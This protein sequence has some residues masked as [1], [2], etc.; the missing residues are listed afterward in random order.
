MTLRQYADKLGIHY[1][2][3]W[4]H[5]KRGLIPQAYQLPT[6]TII[7]PNDEITK[8]EYTVVYC[9]VSSSENRVNLDTQAE[10]VLTYTAAKGYKVG[11]IVKEFGSGV[12]DKRVKLC[13]VLNDPKVTRIVVEHKDRLTRFGFNYLELLCSRLGIEI[14][15]INPVNGDEE[16]IV[17]DFVSI[18]TSFCARI[19]GKRRSKRKTEQ[20]IKELRG[21]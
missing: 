21:D 16:D 12:N 8:S 14:E 1:K 2:T 15:V 4:D 19:Y 17:Q 7:V 20:I 9:R 5:F 13:K 3:A 10:R 18:I 6:G 11:V